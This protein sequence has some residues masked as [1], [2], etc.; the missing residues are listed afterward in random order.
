MPSTE[1]PRAWFYHSPGDG[2]QTFREG[3][4]KRLSLEDLSEPLELG[5]AVVRALPAG[6]KFEV[7]YEEAITCYVLGLE[8]RRAL[9]RRSG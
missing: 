5:R 3:Q 7:G 9:R 2:M 1:S 6:G 8:A 4:I